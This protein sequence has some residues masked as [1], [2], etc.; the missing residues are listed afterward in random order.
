M[1]QL[2]R[3]LAAR[4]ARGGPVYDRINAWA[5]DLTPR[6]ASVPL[7]VAGGLHYLHLTGAAPGLGEVYPPNAASD[8]A[9]IDRV[10][11][12]F[13]DH[14]PFF[15]TWLDSPP[16]T[17]EVRRAA[18]LIAAS[19]WLAAQY[20]LTFCLSELGA[21]AGLNLGFDHFA[22][23]MQG[24]HLGP[25]DPVLTLRPDASG[26]TVSPAR[27]SVAE[28][29]GV[30]LRPVD[31]TDDQHRWRLL[32]YLWPDQPDRLTLTRS[33]IELHHRLGT[34]VDA[35]DAAEWLE[36]RLSSEREGQ[37][38]LIYHTVAWQYFPQ[39]TANRCRNAIEQAGAQATESCPIAWL[40]MENDGVS[41]G[42]GIRLRLWPGDR[43]IDL[44]RIDFHGRWIDWAPTPLE[45]AAR[46]SIF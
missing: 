36:A 41:P 35:G 25:P 16:Q 6:G 38:H 40:G 27:V 13:A 4:V 28:R 12:C 46:A 11:A 37:I 43:N 29:R 20:P 18:V 5:G 34:Q 26:P 3:A 15:E 9:L 14:A 23:V 45:T 22:L 17:N 2:M 10:E 21:S 42:A 19:H 44:G 8:T 31:V 33:A 7:R 32:S 24:I 1:A 30:D 39:S